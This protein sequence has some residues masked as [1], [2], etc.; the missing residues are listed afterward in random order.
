MIDDIELRQLSVETGVPVGTVEKD[1]A[2]TC[3]LYA[4]SRRRLKDHLALRARLSP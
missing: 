1:L 3:V 4:I 2:I